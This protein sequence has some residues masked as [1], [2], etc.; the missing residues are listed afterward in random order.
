MH[1]VSTEEREAKIIENS[2]K[3][4]ILGDLAIFM[5]ADAENEFPLISIFLTDASCEDNRITKL[6]NTKD[7]TLE[8]T[9][10]NGNVFKVNHS[11]VKKG[12]SS[13]FPSVSIS[14]YVL[15]LKEQQGMPD[16]ERNK[17][18]LDALSSYDITNVVVGGHTF[19][20]DSNVE[21][22]FKTAGVFKNM[23]QELKSK[24]IHNENL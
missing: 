18:M 1:F 15:Q 20:F 23:R 2:G 6:L 17:Y 11:I 8:L 21:N 13:L 22:T 12:M 10:S 7:V 5:F 19:I 24:L 14:C 16:K 3:N 4:F 9:L